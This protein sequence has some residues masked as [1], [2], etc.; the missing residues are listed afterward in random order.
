MGAEEASDTGQKTMLWKIA[1]K[2]AQGFLDLVPNFIIK[3]LTSLQR[4]TPFMSNET[5]N[6]W[7]DSLVTKKH[8]DQD[9]ADLLK[10]LAELP[11]PWG[12]IAMVMSVMQVNMADLRIAM[13][14]N[15]M[16]MQYDA[17][18]KATPHPAPI[19]NL[20]R[21]MIIDPG[22]SAENRA[23]LK[24]HGFD[25]LQID[26]IILSYYATV[27]EAVIK[28]NFLRGNITEAMLYER[29]R[30]L[31]YTD[32]RTAEIIQTWSI[33]PGPQDL[34]WMV[35]KEAFEPETIKMLGLDA[36]FPS[37]QSPALEA[38]GISREW[39]EKYWAAHWDQ[40]SIG[41]GFEM[42]HRGEINLEQLN[43]LFKT[44]EMPNF[45]RQKLTNIA[46]KPLTRVDVRRMHDV[47]VVGPER[48]VKAY[49]DLGYN[50][51][52]SLDMA[53]WTIKFNTNNDKELSK[54]SVMSMF[55]DDLISRSEA[56]DL[57]LSLDYDTDLA[58]IYITQAEFDRDKKL[59]D[60]QFDN[61]K[62]MF[63]L[64]MSSETITRDTLNKIGIRPEK[65][66][67]LLTDWKLN[68]YKYQ[69]IPSRSDIDGFLVKGIIT[70]GEWKTL[71]DR[72]GYSVPHMLWI[73]AD[74]KGKV[75]QEGRPPSKADLANWYKKNVILETEWRAEMKLLG[76]NDKY[77]EYYFRS[78]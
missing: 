50:A 51:Q 76:Y 77:I 38:Q 5:W 8:I 67:A 32:A 4:E 65:I 48:L 28:T 78:L 73:L 1:A 31:G 26:N 35:G 37:A 6:K 18:A 9:T 59:L 58:E 75:S 71:M 2:T 29:M 20:V 39:Q 40:P 36:E 57:L 27:P 69:N 54:A 15:S 64:G 72:H 21:S 3:I 22:R 16:D 62:D 47:G 68:K 45:W 66:D 41:Q 33:I 25:D 19:D 12:G 60:L 61:L 63:M 44:V 30:E 11:F 70:E 14:V 7:A 46:Y 42:L 49:A 52:D 17:Q 74:L 24:Q 34:F 43:V 10:P 13:D 53:N 56:L 23:K 55:E